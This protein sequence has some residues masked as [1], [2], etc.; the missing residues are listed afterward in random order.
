MVGLRRSKLKAALLFR[1]MELVVVQVP[2]TS[3][4]GAMT[5]RSPLCKIFDNSSL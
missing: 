5:E 4:P 2:P 3:L 1:S